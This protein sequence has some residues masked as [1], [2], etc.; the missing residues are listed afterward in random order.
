M[1]ITSLFNWFGRM[2]MMGLLVL[3][4]LLGFGMLIYVYKSRMAQLLTLGTFAVI[5]F[6]ML[7]NMTI[8]FPTMSMLDFVMMALPLCGG[9]ALLAKAHHKRKE[10]M[11]IGKSDR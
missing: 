3:P 9:A 4:L 11:Q 7:T 6:V 2:P 1:Q 5:L 10:V 8:V